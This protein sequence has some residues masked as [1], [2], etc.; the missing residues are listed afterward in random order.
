MFVLGVLVGI[1][2]SIAGLSAFAI[3]IVRDITE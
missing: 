2:I 1:A 3:W